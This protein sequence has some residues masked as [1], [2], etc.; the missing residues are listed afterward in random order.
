MKT[1]TFSKLLI[2]GGYGTFGGRLAG[3]LA[4][5]PELTLLIAGRSL[6]KAEQFIDRNSAQATM[7]PVRFDRNG[8]VA[9]QVATLTPDVVIDASGPY[10]AYGER[11][12]RVAEAAIAIG[13]HYLDLADGTDFVCNIA[14]LDTEARNKDVFVLAGTSTCPA[15]TMAVTRML[16]SDLICVDSITGG[17][18]PSPFAGMGRSVV[19]A[20]AGYA[21][22]S[23]Q[24]IRDGRLQQEHTFISTRRFTIAPP[25]EVPLPPM[26]FSLIDVPDLRLLGNLDKPVGNTWFGV[27]TTPSVYHRL[28]RTLARGVK[29]GILPT[30]R[31]LAGIMHFVMN[32]LGWGEHRGGMFMEVRGT[33][34]LGRKVCRSWHLIATGDSGPMVPAL[35][36]AA[37][38][39]R[40]INGRFPTSGARPAMDVSDLNDYL[41]MFEELCIRT[42]ERSESACD[43]PPIFEQVL[44]EKWDKLPAPIRALHGATAASCFAGRASVIRGDGLIAKIIGLIAG[45][46]DEGTDVPVTVRISPEGAHEIWTRDFD[47]HTFSSEMSA[48]GG[49]LAALMCERFGP[50]KFG[51]ALVTEGDILRYVFRR[52]T[53][54][55]MP[56]PKWL[57]PNG[58]TYESSVDGKFAFH[59]EITLPLIGHVVT[60]EGYLEKKPLDFQ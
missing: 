56:M 1:S 59:V 8:D 30:L 14:T 39:R 3:L 44:G 28:L 5:N 41:P 57:M 33:D 34:A 19:Q 55:G 31:P 47:G 43:D 24:V 38:I 42:G 16:S 2:I 15:L 10:Q 23:V 51:M 46:P 18:A 9:A 17:I 48:G 20:I 32:H 35:A 6:H 37:V 13:A 21:G 60:Y 29:A 45:F 7:I 25:G 11:P 36:A 27:S 26:T 54:L 50:C 53:F 52:W 58:K 22:K 4:E 12:Y 40:C 49:R